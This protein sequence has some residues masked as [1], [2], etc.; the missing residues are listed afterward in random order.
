MRHCNKIIDSFIELGFKGLEFLPFGVLGLQQTEVGFP[1]VSDNFT[2][3]ETTNRDNHL[4]ACMDCR[5]NLQ[6]T[7]SKRRI[8]LVFDE[9]QKFVLLCDDFGGGVRLVGD[10][11]LSVE[12]AS[13]KSKA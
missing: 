12:E 10:E 9:T 5:K 7:F 3:S 1:L 8:F 11:K 13:D 4:E 6:S 2:A